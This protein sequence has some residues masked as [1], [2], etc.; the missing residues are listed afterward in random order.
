MQ[1]LNKSIIRLVLTFAFVVIFMPLAISI[2]SALGILL[3]IPLGLAAL[4]TFT[5]SMKFKVNRSYSHQPHE[6]ETQ[7][8][9]KSKY[10]NVID[11]EDYQVIDRKK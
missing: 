5:K 7:K 2:F 3:L 8:T 1:N 10:A 4:F 6:Q 9:K 11:C